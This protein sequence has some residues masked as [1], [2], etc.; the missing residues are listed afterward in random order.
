[1]LTGK[2]AA[3]DFDRQATTG[4]GS[5][6]SPHSSL[7]HSHQ[8]AVDVVGVG[9]TTRRSGEHTCIL[10]YLLDWIQGG[11]LAARPI[12]VWNHTLTQFRG[13]N[14]PHAPISPRVNRPID[15]R[16]GVGVVM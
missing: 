9:R 2:A 11:V 16:R 13:V 10:T 12:V 14:G 3:R 15:L 1:V 4:Y 6:V 7:L 8:S 5:C